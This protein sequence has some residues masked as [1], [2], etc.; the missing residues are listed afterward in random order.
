VTR[1]RGTASI[2]IVLI[3]LILAWQSYIWESHIP[4]YVLPTPWQTAT[5]LGDNLSLLA[6][7]SL[8][9]IEGAV[10]GLAAS[11]ALSILLALI[12]VRWP[13]A[14]HVILTYAVLIRT[15]PIVGVAPIIILVS[16]RGLATSVLCVMVITVFSL[17]V[18]MIQGFESIPSEITELGDLYATP[19][20]RRLKVAFLPGAVANLLLGLRI[21]A[22]LAVL[23]ALIAE[24]LDGFQGIGSL[25]VSAYFDQETSLL[26]AACATA[27]L[28]SLL[29]YAGVELASAL[30]AR[31]GYRVDD[32]VIAGQ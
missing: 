28:L 4:P 9:T 1:T 14:K 17:L 15:L 7:R 23:A 24:W 18:S 30:G 27:V 13:L 3:A 29:A 26:M 16:G 31:R 8:L 5:T 21:A 10:A 12:I 20:L 6:Q 32:I 11:V 25:M 22:P 2:V 19:F